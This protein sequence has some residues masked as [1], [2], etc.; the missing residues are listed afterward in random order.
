MLSESSAQDLVKMK[1]FGVAVEIERISLKVFEAALSERACWYRV[2]QMAI[3]YREKN[4]LGVSM[5]A[6]V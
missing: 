1:E 5:K 6:K 4:C 3:G 2:M